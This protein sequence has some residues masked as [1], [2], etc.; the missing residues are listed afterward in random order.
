[1]TLASRRWQA[2]PSCGRRAGTGGSDR[3]C[4]PPHLSARDYGVAEVGFGAGPWCKQGIGREL[5]AAVEGDGPAAS[6]RQPLPG[7]ADP[8][9]QGIGLTVRVRQQDGVAGLALDHAGQVGLAVLTAE[10]QQIRLP[11]A[12]GLAILD[13]DRPV[14]DSAG[15][16]DGAMRAA[17]GRSVAGA[18]DGL[19]ADGGK[20]RRPDLQA[21]RCTDRSSRDR[22]CPRSALSSFSRP[23]ICSGDQQ[24]SSLSMT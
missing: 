7:L 19:W 6:F 22:R 14:L 13:L 17:C 15:G 21:R 1:M 24:R 4:S 23:A 3:W 9:D 11:M 12:K 2:R 5:G 18:A 20:D 16:G 10:D 8:P